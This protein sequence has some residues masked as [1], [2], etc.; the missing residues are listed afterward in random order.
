MKLE[1]VIGRNLAW[2][3][4]TQN[5]S[6]AQMGEALSPYLE[7]PWSRQAVNS[8]ERGNRAFTARDLVAL[9]LALDVPV[10]VLLLPRNEGAVDLPG[11][12]LTRDEYRRAVMPPYSKADAAASADASLQRVHAGFG[13]MLELYRRIGAE[14]EFGLGVLS[15]AAEARS[16]TTVGT[17]LGGRDG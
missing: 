11:V 14:I 1:E 10:S 3:R 4:G 17:E 8:A 12:A 2:V 15:D 6:Q 9:A 5:L 13:Q 16:E 7:K